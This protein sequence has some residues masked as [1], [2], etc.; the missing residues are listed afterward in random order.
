[1]RLSLCSHQV[2][3]CLVFLRVEEVVFS[4]RWLSRA[5]VGTS[6]SA[7]QCC[8]TIFILRSS[9]MT[10]G[11]WAAG[12]GNAGAGERTPFSAASRHSRTSQHRRVFHRRTCALL[13]SDVAATAD[14]PQHSVL[15]AQQLLD[16]THRWRKEREDLDIDINDVHPLAAPVH[17]N[18][19]LH[20]A[21]YP[22]PAPF[23]RPDPRKPA[24]SLTDL[25]TAIAALLARC[26]PH[27]APLLDS[28]R[29]VHEV[30]LGETLPSTLLPENAATRS[31]LPA[32][33]SIVSRARLPLT[34]WQAG[35]CASSTTTSETAHS[36]WIPDQVAS[37]ALLGSSP[38]C[39]GS[40]S[41]TPG[42]HWGHAALARSACFGARPP[43]L[44][45]L[46]CLALPSQF[47]WSRELLL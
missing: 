25:L 15:F 17:K 18:I 14:L 38:V 12:G 3:N 32:G 9:S 26:Q 37:G 24:R 13:L 33:D 41:N 44:P 4:G 36:P 40:A 21:R 19:K 30:R 11:L 1:M 20:S 5:M 42:V 29:T 35:P 45:T 10:T 46:L 7:D 23:Q 28:A 27:N 22:D 47:V 43:A 39:F 16:L 31:A 2:S 8:S 34:Y 6:Y